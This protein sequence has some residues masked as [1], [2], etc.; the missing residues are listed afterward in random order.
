M[1]NSEKYTSPNNW[2]QNTVII[3]FLDFLEVGLA[4]IRFRFCDGTTLT[5]R[6]KMKLASLK[7]LMLASLLQS[8]CSDQNFAAEE[9]AP[10]EKKH[11][12][13][14]NKSADSNITA[15]DAADPVVVTGTYL[16]CAGVSSIDPNTSVYGCA[17][18]TAP[19][20]KTTPPAGHT[21]DFFALSGGKL[22]EPITENEQSPYHV[23]FYIPNF[24]ARDLT[25]AA[26]PRRTSELRPESM[27]ANPQFISKLHLAPIFDTP[28][29]SKL[30]INTPIAV[31]NNLQL[32]QTI[33]YTMASRG[34][35]LSNPTCRQSNPLS[36][37]TGSAG[38][39]KVRAI[40]CSKNGVPSLV[41]ELNYTV[42]AP[43]KPESPPPSS[44]SQRKNCLCKS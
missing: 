3:A 17:L 23:K 32:G 30:K 4:F 44:C 22:Y 35:A 11:K 16:S 12:T 1:A 43:S 14:T 39:Y 7:I 42:E 37:P 18:Q 41:Q 6:V 21:Y 36:Y 26:Q 33:R 24:A 25:V 9:N 40:I 29:N 38:Q 20:Q 34:A 13:E 27:P 10:A 28:E 31:L 5:L 19:N 2:N 15:I 8:S